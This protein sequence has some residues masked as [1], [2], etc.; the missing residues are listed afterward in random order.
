MHPHLAPES[1]LFRATAAASNIARQ[2]FH[3]SPRPNITGNSGFLFQSQSPR[4]VEK[5]VARQVQ[6]R[7]DAATAARQ[8]PGVQ[9]RIAGVGAEYSD[10]V[11]DA[12][13]RDDSAI[14]HYLGSDTE[15][16]HQ[17]VGGSS[18]RSERN[19]AQRQIPQS[20]NPYF[21]LGDST[22]G[23]YHIVGIHVFTFRSIN[24]FITSDSSLLGIYTHVQQH[25]A[26][27]MISFFVHTTKKCLFIHQKFFCIHSSWNL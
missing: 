26:M 10:R 24:I 12:L 20:K 15:Q 5:Q 8:D 1:I 2:M 22:D 25:E 3:T 21:C 17:P 18:R 13:F 19:V 7:A 11:A 27:Q 4:T 23:E 16:Q 9:D 6:D 14:I